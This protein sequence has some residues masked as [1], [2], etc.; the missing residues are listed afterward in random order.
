MSYFENWDEKYKPTKLSEIVGQ[1]IV[2]R[3]AQGYVNKKRMPHLLFAGAAGVGKT[4]TLHAIAHEMFGDK[5]EYNTH[6]FNATKNRGIEFVRKDIADLTSV[7][8]VGAPFQ[9]IFL[10]EV[11]GFT[12]DAQEALREIMQAHTA[13]TKFV[14]GCNYINNIISPIQDRC[15]V[16]RFTRLTPEAIKYRLAEIAKLENVSISDDALWYLAQTAENGSLRSAIRHLQTF[17]EDEKV[18][19]LETVQQD[20]P[21]VTIPAKVLLDAALKHDIKTYEEQL[22]KLHYSGGFIATEILSKMLSEILDNKDFKPEYK[23]KLIDHI[24]EYEW[25]ISQGA[26]ELLQMR[27]FLSGLSRIR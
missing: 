3:R 25:R 16:F 23:Q 22:F 24:G 14:L 15:R 5:W 10:D 12:K 4:S 27:C 18:I 21:S 17:A 26:N 2:Q 6:I 8:P 13:T 20:L 7:T 19:T 1:P 11:D 9:I